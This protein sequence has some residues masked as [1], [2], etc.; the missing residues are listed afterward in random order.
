MV[1]LF[2][3]NRRITG[4]NITRMGLVGFVVLIA[5]MVLEFGSIIIIII[6]VIIIIII[7]IQNFKVQ[8]NSEKC[9]NRVV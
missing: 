7:L 1:R 9:I 2:T 5:P 3:N 8:E 6:F 4:T